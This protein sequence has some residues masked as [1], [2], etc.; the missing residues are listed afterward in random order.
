MDRII[1]SKQRIKL[2]ILVSFVLI[3]GIFS[4]YIP[5]NTTHSFIHFKTLI[6]GFIFIGVFVYWIFSIRERIMYPQVRRYLFLVGASIVFWISI[7]TIKFTCLLTTPVLDRI[8]W[9]SYYIPMI[10][11]PLLLFYVSFTIGKDENYKI[12]PKWYLLNIP[13][14]ILFLFVITSEFHDFVFIIDKTKHAYK[15]SYSHGFFYYLI[16]VFIFTMFVSATTILARNC[17]KYSNKIPIFPIAV[18]SLG[19]I[20]TVLYVTNDWFSKYFFLDLTLFGCFIVILLLESFVYCGLIHSNKNYKE[21]FE[22]AN[23]DTQI[24]DLDGEIKYISDNTSR[25][26][27][28]DFNRLKT[29]KSIEI[30]ENI[31]HYMSEIRGGYISYTSDISDFRQKINEL[32]RINLDLYE[33]IDLLTRENKQKESTILIKKQTEVQDILL[34]EFKHKSLEMRENVDNIQTENAKS[35]LFELLLD[36]VYIK[37]KV[38]LILTAQTT[39]NISVK[40]LGFCFDETF[41]I[42]KLQDKACAINFLKTFEMSANSSMLCYDLFNKV[43]K[44]THNDFNAVLI[45]FNE[46]QGNVVF[47]IRAD[48]NAKEP[49]AL[50]EF[51]SDKLASINGKIAVINDDDDLHIEF[52]FKK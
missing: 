19:V 45:S 32:E 14:V 3:V 1:L 52:V 26:N 47:I 5:Q 51:E 33:E 12:N 38:N 44:L 28:D 41:R 9:Y 24:L 10:F 37:R 49:L 2:F 43:I 46:A 7:R 42:L 40:D 15:Q 4:E 29:E 20:Y 34:S 6:S 11:I 27:K 8:A 22:K 35:A 17:R 30:N 21:F 39:E 25:L 18:I 16:V 36:S 13:A 48:C 23:L 31:L 50:A